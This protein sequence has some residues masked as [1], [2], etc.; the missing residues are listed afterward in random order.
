[1]KHLKLLKV[2]KHRVIFLLI[3]DIHVRVIDIFSIKPVDKE[4]LIE[5]ISAVG[6]K[7]IVAE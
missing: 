6:G 7:V 3:L 1:M 4:G 5:N 2:F